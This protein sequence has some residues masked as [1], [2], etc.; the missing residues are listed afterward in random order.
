MKKR[1]LIILLMIG[2]L[3]ITACEKQNRDAAEFKK[4]YESYN[5]K[6]NNNGQKYRKLT[7]ESD[8]PIKY[9]TADEIV[10]KID[11][12]EDLIVYF[13]FATCP[14]CRSILQNMFLSA[15]DN[16]IKEIY[17]V[18]VKEIRDTL[19]VDSEGRIK[20][21]TQGTKSYYEL[22]DRLNNILADY[23]V[24]DSDGNSINT[25][26]KRIYAP[27]I[28]IIK[29]GK[30]TNLITAIPDSLQDPYGEI[31][32]DMNEYMYDTFTSYFSNFNK[33]VCSQKG[34]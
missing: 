2:G 7:I 33:N 8:N 34:C 20:T 24:L 14:W 28:V 12:K 13:G 15:K 23:T 25:M 29:E 5:E 3:F 21:I 31:T 18:D 16:N 26:E 30:G 9:A 22:I 10:R 1:I 19:E 17:Y 11:N 6:E 4:E 27:N 32:D